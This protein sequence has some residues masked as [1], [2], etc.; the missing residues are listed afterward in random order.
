MKEVSSPIKIV[1]IT[2]VFVMYIILAILYESD[3]HSL[4]FISSASGNGGRATGVDSFPNV[5]IIL[6]P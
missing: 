6:R 2:A 5:I 3:I 4:H 1:L